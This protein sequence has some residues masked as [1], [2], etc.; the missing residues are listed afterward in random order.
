[1]SNKDYYICEICGSRLDPGEDCSICR[2]LGL[3][4]KNHFIYP[5]SCDKTKHRIINSINDDNVPITDE[6]SYRHKILTH[7]ITKM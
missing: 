6:E 1:M 7:K 2:E 3:N 5:K 4:P